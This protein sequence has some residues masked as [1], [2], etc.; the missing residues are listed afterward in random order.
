[1]KKHKV[2]I[3]KDWRNIKME[4][5]I[6]S[7]KYE[8][9]FE[10]KTFGGKAY[11]YYTATKV[12]I[13]DLVVAPTAYG[14]KIARVSEINIPEEKIQSIKPY[15]KTIILKIDKEKYLQSEQ[16]LEEAA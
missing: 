3:I 4:T 16:V 1:M 2:S 14:D 7:V 15:L 10:P 11:S 5:N 12:E 13:G 6:I 9:N 8:D